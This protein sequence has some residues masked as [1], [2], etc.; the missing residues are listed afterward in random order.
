MVQLVALAMAFRLESVLLVKMSPGLNEVPRVRL[1]VLAVE[2]VPNTSLAE[3]YT[4]S[5]SLLAV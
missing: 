1:R 3:P 4:F 5:V 2:P